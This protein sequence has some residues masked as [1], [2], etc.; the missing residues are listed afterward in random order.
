N[1]RE[2]NRSPFLAGSGDMQREH[3]HSEQTAREIDE[4]VKRIIDESF[5]K[6]RHILE[7]RIS[8]LQALSARLIE[9]EVIDS[10]ELKQIIEA[11]SPSPQIVPGTTTDRKRPATEGIN[12]EPGEQAGE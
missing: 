9:K 4:E 11:N 8:S 2:S 12:I 10:D 1:F 6:V 5:E 3:S 7:T